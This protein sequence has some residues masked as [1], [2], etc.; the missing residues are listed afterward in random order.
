MQEKRQRNKDLEK[1]L[2]EF[3]KKIIDFAVRLPRTASN[4]IL[5]KQLIR[6][7]TSITANYLE[8]CESLTSK[9][10]VHKI[11][12]SKKES[13]ETIFWLILISHANKEFAG[14]SDL[15]AKECE[16]FLKI[17]GSIIGKFRN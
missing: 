4:L 17:F 1:R 13:R 6:A 3:S 9:E 8:A 5:I 15:L 11:S 7:G 10:F 2:I 14:E 16:E 12:I